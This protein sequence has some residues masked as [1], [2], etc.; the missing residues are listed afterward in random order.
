MPVP[1]IIDNIVKFQYLC[2]NKLF[3]F[4]LLY[5]CMYRWS[6][7]MDNITQYGTKLGNDKKMCDNV[8]ILSPLVSGINMG[9]D[10]AKRIENLLR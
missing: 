4:R 6:F 8:N 1:F 2:I 3:L 5:A 9:P 10:F 7:F